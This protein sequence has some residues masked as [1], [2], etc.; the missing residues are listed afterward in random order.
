MLIFTNRETQAAT[1]PSAFTR[2]FQPGSEALSSAQVLR[3]GS[4]FD[5]GELRPD[6]KDDDA[7]QLL[8]PV[9]QGPKPVLVYLHGNNNAPAACFERC[10]RLAEIYGVEVIG[11]SWPSEGYLSSGSELPKLAPAVM[12]SAD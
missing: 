5:L 9:F 4:G 3:N 6:L 8:V 10:A 1:D 11:F 7:M 12:A 2:K